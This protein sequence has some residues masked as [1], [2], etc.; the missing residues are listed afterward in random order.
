M[1]NII[2]MSVNKFETKVLQST[3]N[4]EEESRISI[5]YYCETIFNLFKLFYLQAGDHEN[6][7]K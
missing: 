6:K 2:Y 3:P 7:I 1:E 4:R 5:I